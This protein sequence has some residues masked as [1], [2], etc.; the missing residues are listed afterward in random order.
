MS[1]WRHDPSK[2][3]KTAVIPQESTGIAADSQ[4]AVTATKTAEIE[5]RPGGQDAPIPSPQTIFSSADAAHP[6]GG[7]DLVDPVAGRGAVAEVDDP[8]VLWVASARR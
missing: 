6:L 1:L 7:D 5:Q 3:E 2:P 4:S 8:R